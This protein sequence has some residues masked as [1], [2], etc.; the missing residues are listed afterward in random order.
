MERIYEVVVRQ[1]DG[2]WRAE[3]VDLQG[4]H[5]WADDLAML[6]GYV[7]DVIRRVED[8]PDDVAISIRYRDAP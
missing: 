3:V 6:D 8:L 7:H 1:E 2:K 5:T 4:A